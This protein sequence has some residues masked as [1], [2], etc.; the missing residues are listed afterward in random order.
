MKTL[1][2]SLRHAFWAALCAA[3]ASQ[4]ACLLPNFE[5]GSKETQVCGL[6]SDVTDT[7]RACIA[8]KCCEEAMTCSE[9]EA[10]SAD[11]GKP[12]HPAQDFDPAFDP[13]LG[14]MQA[15]C[16]AACDVNWGCVDDYAFPNRSASYDVQVATVDFANE[17]PIDA[18]NVKV[19]RAVDP[20][21]RNGLLDEDVSD[22]GSATLTLPGNFDGFFAFEGGSFSGAPYVNSTVQWSEPIYRLTDFTHYM[23]SEPNL[24]AFA[25]L[26]EYL[27]SA[28]RTE[29]DPERGHLIVRTQ[30]CLP[31]RYL[32]TEQPPLA[33]T[34][35]IVVE[36]QPHDGA[37]R[38]YYTEVNGL[39]SLPLEETTTDG[40][41]G[42]FELPA[43]TVTV[44]AKRADTGEVVA[45][46][47][48]PVRPGEIA[49]AYMVAR[50]QR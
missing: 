45:R 40:V 34:A 33:E 48:L 1:A 11:F 4:P 10:C 16:E 9:D 21:C 27:S 7:C 35:G 39:V 41:A 6:E 24:Y 5:Q 32:G 25:G 3:G 47:T 26:T 20:D 2:P 46:T 30:G 23:I 19:C 31:L 37:S 22:S 15:Q 14:C 49:F 28:G 18:V 8:Q 50:A 43:G 42:A 13:M 17:T 36:A 38:F 44:T 12:I 29:F